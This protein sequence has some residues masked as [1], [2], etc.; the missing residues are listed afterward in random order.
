M[1]RAARPPRAI[2]WVAPLAAA[3]AVLAVG[4]VATVLSLHPN[5][6]GSPAP[7]GGDSG[8]RWLGARG[9]HRR[10]HFA[11]GPALGVPLASC[12]TCQSPDSRCVYRL[13]LG[14]RACRSRHS[15]LAKSPFVRTSIVPAVA[16]CRC[17]RRGLSRQRL[18]AAARSLRPC[19]CWRWVR[20]LAAN[21]WGT[22]WI[23]PFLAGCALCSLITP[24]RRLA[25][26][27]VAAWDQPRLP[28][29]WMRRPRPPVPADG[30]SA[31]V[32]HLARQPASS[33]G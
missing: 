7:L 10:E 16:G 19:R 8:R 5:L 25:L 32:D 3:A 23:D 9:A 28:P 31:S 11:A 30:G 17:T 21:Q 20:G 18:G 6:G 24:V 4:I 13:L 27:T 33:R 26:G 14:I 22:R 12:V 29:G 2:A 1:P 15:W